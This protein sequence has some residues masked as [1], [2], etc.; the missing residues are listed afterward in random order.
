MS[1]STLKHAMTTYF[2]ILSSS[3]YTTIVSPHLMPNTLHC[4]YSI[5]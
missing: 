1:A 5:T 4:C 3:L 2:C